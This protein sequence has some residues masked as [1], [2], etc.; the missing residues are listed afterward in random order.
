M[1]TATNNK[2]HAL[3][4]LSRQGAAGAIIGTLALLSCY[5]VLALTVLLPLLGI[6]V[7]LDESLWAGTIV[8]LAVLTAAA[9]LP[10]IAA[11]GAWVPA[12]AAIGGAGL[13]VHALLVHYDA[14][15]ELAGFLLL[16]VA[17]IRDVYLHRRARGTGLQRESTPG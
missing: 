12:V 10:G 9:V 13:V 17:V 1:N 7:A 11:H 5:G 16:A 2:R 3:A 8:V 14:R 15:I 6:R 4:R